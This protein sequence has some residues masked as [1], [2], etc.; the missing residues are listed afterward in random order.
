MSPCSQRELSSNRLQGLEW[1]AP[2][3]HIQALAPGSRDDA[4]IWGEVFAEMYNR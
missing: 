2:T 4:L 1:W 3:R